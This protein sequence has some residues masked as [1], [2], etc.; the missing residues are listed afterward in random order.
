MFVYGPIPDGMFVCHKCDNPGCVRPSH[1]FLGTPLDNTRD[2]IAKGRDYRGERHKWAKLTEKQ[3]G[4]IRDQLAAGA[5]QASLA[6]E[7]GVVPG[8]IYNI[9]AGLCWKRVST[10]GK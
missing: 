5:S 8:H 2:S 6:R 9:S 7:Y 1:L 3:V 4:A 10:E